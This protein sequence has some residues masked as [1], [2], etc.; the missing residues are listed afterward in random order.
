MKRR[1]L[2]ICLAEYPPFHSSGI[3]NCVYCLVNQLKKWIDC[4][5]CSPVGSDIELCNGDILKR[6]SD[7]YVGGV[8]PI[9]GTYFWY[10]VNKYLQT[11]SCNKYDIVWIHNPT[12]FFLKGILKSTYNKNLIT[13]H[14]T[15]SFY[16]RNQL[17]HKVM[18]GIVSMA[19]NHS[20]QNQ[21]IN[22]A[23]FTAV[24]PEVAKELEWLGVNREKIRYIPNGVNTELFK[25][26]NNKKMLRKKFGIP[27]NDL[28]ILSI[29]RLTEAK[30]PFKLI[31]VFSKIEKEMKDVTLVIAGKGE[32]LERTKEFAEEKKLKNVIFLGYVEHEKEAPDLYACSDYYIM[33]S[34]YEGQPL[35]L[36]EAMASG[37]PCIVSDIPNLK[38]VEEAKCGL[39]V[40]FNDIEKVAEEI[41]EYFGEDNPRHAKNAREYAVKNL[42]WEVIARRYLEELEKIR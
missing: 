36:L 10:R 21:V 16:P 40:D 38:I 31:E 33:A 35:T 34:K 29:G 30:Q 5:V 15:T 24:N 13:I 25:P 14:T 6:F 23:R 1:K 19:E 11:N 28:V 2:L 20:F 9:Y 26:S 22:G 8:R 12:P 18:L 27:E 7:F 17:I 3:G 32:L 37:L 42:D 39:I 41:V 4:R